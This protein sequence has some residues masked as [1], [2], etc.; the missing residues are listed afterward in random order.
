MQEDYNI[1]VEFSDTKKIYFRKWKGKE[2]RLLQKIIDEEI[3]LKIE[4]ILIYECTNKEVYLSKKEIAYAAFI[5]YVHSF[6]QDLTGIDE[7][8]NCLIESDILISLNDIISKAKI[9]NYNEEIIKINNDLGINFDEQL[10]ITTEF[11][12]IQSKTML[13]SDKFFN[14]IVAGINFYDE[15][16][17]IKNFQSFQNKQDFLDNL[18]IEIFDKIVGEYVKQSFNFSPEFEYSCKECNT[19]NRVFV[20]IINELSTSFYS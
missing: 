12:N 10:L 2:R 13:D 18:D 16:N 14:E 15:N 5:L 3:D 7:C 6:E 9:T 20:D 17:T 8:S 11:K 1:L 19:V 4:D